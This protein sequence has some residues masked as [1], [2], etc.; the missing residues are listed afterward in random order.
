[1]KK[2]VHRSVFL[3]LR[4]SQFEI[5]CL[6]PSWLVLFSSSKKG[7]NGIRRGETVVMGQL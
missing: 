3:P 4:L 7:K 5:G 6:V 1:M 2:L